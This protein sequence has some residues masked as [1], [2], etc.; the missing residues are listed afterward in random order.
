[1][2]RTPPSKG[3]FVAQWIVFIIFGGFGLVLAGVG[4]TQAIRQSRT[5]AAAHPVPATIIHS[6]VFKSTSHDTDQRLG[7]D[8]ST[9][10]YRPDVRFR[11]TVVETEYESDLLHP[12]IIV[13]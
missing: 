2:N 10:S 13:Q 11:Y 1:M 4:V 12:T 5:L 9:N 6:E 7:R 3:R 8:N